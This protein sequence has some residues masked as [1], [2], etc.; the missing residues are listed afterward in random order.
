MTDLGFSVPKQTYLGIK[1]QLWGVHVRDNR[2]R[3]CFVE[4]VLK[5]Q[6]VQGASFKR[7]EL[8][9]ITLS[10]L[11]P[12]AYSYMHKS[13][14]MSA[15]CRAHLLFTGSIKRLLLHKLSWY[16]NLAFFCSC[17][18]KEKQGVKKSFQ[19]LSWKWV[20]HSSC[21]VTPQKTAVSAHLHHCSFIILPFSRC[22]HKK[23]GLSDWCFI[24]E[25]AAKELK[26]LAGVLR[27]GFPSVAA[28]E[29]GIMIHCSRRHWSR[30]SRQMFA[31]SSG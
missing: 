27:R 12:S 21:K 9:P 28:S 8:L 26:V 7:W 17:G 24:R 25:S 14:C 16:M 11:I 29:V 1:K 13:C 30:A 3:I 23:R 2:I 18:D 31:C 20:R 10:R 19:K 5:P 22:R 6:R 4:T 15:G